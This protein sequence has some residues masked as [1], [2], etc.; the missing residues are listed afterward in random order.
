[1][2]KGLIISDD[3]YLKKE[4]IE[5]INS[6]GDIKVDTISTI[7]EVAHEINFFNYLFIIISDF[8]E[9]LISKISNVESKSPGLSVLFYNHSLNI[10]TFPDAVNRSKVKM[11][12]GEN[13]ESNLQEQIEALK[14]KFWRKIPYKQFGINFKGL[15]TRM[16][17]VMDYIETAPIRDCNINK[18]SSLLNISAG[19]FSQEFKRETNRS[20]RT[21]MQNI[22]SYYENIIFSKVNLSAKNISQILG[23]SEPSSFSRSFKN[24]KGMSPSKFKKTI[25]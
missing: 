4:C 19:Y 18:I 9:K 15:S 10:I 21:F 23:Y 13:R 24:R 14:S 11:V 6:I 8:E 22:I 16:K 25:Y 2:Y 1:M 20:F 5:I 7:E 3:I 12:I 17:I